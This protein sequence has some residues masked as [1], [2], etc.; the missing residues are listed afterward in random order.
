MFNWKLWKWRSY[1]YISDNNID[2]WSL[3]NEIFVR[4]PCKHPLEHK[5][6]LSAQEAHLW[7]P[8]TMQRSSTT[9][10]NMLLQQTFNQLL[11]C[12]VLMTSPWS[13]TLK[14]DSRH[15]ME[16]HH[17]TPHVIL[18]FPAMALRHIAGVPRRASSNLI[19]IAFS[20]CARPLL[21]WSR[22]SFICVSLR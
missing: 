7:C 11:G 16:R 17:M 4:A 14:L 15:F 6:S 1:Q 18:F 8:S 10:A 12:G 22:T 20:P 21:A 9:L 13:I 2:T 5:Q 3:L 19:H